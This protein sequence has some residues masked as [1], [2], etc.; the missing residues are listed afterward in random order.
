MDALRRYVAAKQ[1]AVE[2]ALDAAVQPPSAWNRKLADAMRYSLLGGG[3]RLRPMLVL[4]A[5]ELFGGSEA[6]AMPTAVAVEM[7]HT[8]SLVHDDLP[9]MDD[10]DVRRSR[11]TSHRMY[12][13]DVAILAGDALLSEAFR[14]I[15][16]E[17]PVDRVPAERV[18]HVLRLLGDSVGLRGLAAGQV[19]D[20]ACDG[21]GVG[22]E[23]D[24]NEASAASANAAELD[25]LEWIHLH[26]TAALLRFSVVA[27]AVLAGAGADDVARLETFANKIG[28]A[29]QIA[30]DVL[31]VTMSTERLGKTAGKDVQANKVTF[32]RLLGVDASRQRAAALVREAK[33]ALAGVRADAGDNDED[34]RDGAHADLDARMRVLCGLADFVVQRGS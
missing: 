32:P 25:T 23:G 6:Q 16:A 30:D 12:G 22:E 18:L 31:D 33:H 29:F 3:K 9:S 27:G 17:T 8:M 28:L 2:C 13:E 5:C 10:D 1:P 20:L 19:M 15:A 14:H 34:E 11:P 21:V 4:A 26:K 24:R 7:V